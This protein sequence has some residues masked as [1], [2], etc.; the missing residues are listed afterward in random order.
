MKT[1]L[2]EDATEHVIKAEYFRGPYLG[3]AEPVLPADTD[4]ALLK[5]LLNNIARE[6]QADGKEKIFIIRIRP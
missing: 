5:N 6:A 4:N 1:Y 3:T 2:E